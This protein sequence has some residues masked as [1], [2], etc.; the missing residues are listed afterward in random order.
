MRINLNCPYPEKDEAKRLGARWDNARKV[1]YL[2]NVEDLTPFMRWMP[3]T[4]PSTE[5]P[6]VTLT[7]STE[8]EMEETLRQMFVQHLRQKKGKKTKTNK[9]PV[10]EGEVYATTGTLEHAC[11]CAALPWDDCEHTTS[12]FASL[13]NPLPHPQQ[14]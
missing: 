7:K 12:T 6:P 3:S 9:R 2:E 11:T 13:T 8:I 5:A 4:Q 10:R 14:D 1:W